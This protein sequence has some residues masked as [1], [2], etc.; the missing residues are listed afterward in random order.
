MFSIIIIIVAVLFAVLIVSGC[1]AGATIGQNLDHLF[2][3]T[4]EALNDTI[5]WWGQ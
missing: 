5:N 3:K 4:G 1:I 2:N